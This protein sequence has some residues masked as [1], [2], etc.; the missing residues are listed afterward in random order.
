MTTPIPPDNAAAGQAG[1]I[2]AHNQIS[3]VLQSHD[4][5][6]RALPGMAWGTATL[7]SG[8]VSVPAGAV[9]ASSVILVSR[10]SPSGALGHLSVPAV[11]PGTGFTISSSS[12]TDNSVVGYLIL[13]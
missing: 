3:D 11:S 4:D 6:I 7:V 12:G 10:L 1:H 2:G 13:G 8:S 9:T 5:A